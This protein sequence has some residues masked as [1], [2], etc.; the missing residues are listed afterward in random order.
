[1][2]VVEGGSKC[3]LIEGYAL[4]EDS[5]VEYG[6]H[7]YLAQTFTLD[8]DY[9]VLRFRLKSW[10]QTGGKFYHYA[11]RKTDAAGKPLGEDIYHTTLSPSNEYFYSPGKWKRFDFIEF[12]Q[13]PAG[14][15]A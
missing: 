15:Y 9:T 10:T 8:D 3:N 1:M 13:L 6:R 12:P 11:I 14:T 7:R 5:D 2:A 4:G